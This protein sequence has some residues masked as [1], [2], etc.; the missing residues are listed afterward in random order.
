MSEGSH[1]P[2]AKPDYD[3]V[4]KEVVQYLFRD[5]LALLFPEVEQVIDWNHDPE[6]VNVELPKLLPH[7]LRKLRRPDLVA[8]VQLADGTA[9]LIVVHVEIQ[10][11]PD[12][13]FAERMFVYFYHLRERHQ[14][15]VVSLA[16]L[17]DNQPSWNPTEYRYERLGTRV[18]F[19]YHAK[20][21]IQM[22]ET[23]LQSTENPFALFVRAHIA[24]L[25]H[26]G[27]YALLAEEKKRLFRQMLE[28]GYNARQVRYLFQVVDYLMSLPIDIE[29]EVEA[30]VE[31]VRR[32]RRRKWVAP[33]ERLI[34]ERG[35]LQGMEQ[36]VREGTARTIETLLKARFG[37]LPQEVHARLQ[38]IQSPDVLLELSV[39]AMQAPNLQAFMEDLRRATPEINPSSSEKSP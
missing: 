28:G 17:A 38:A 13:Q 14:M 36:G 30:L 23:F 7:N 33:R 9:T 12:P 32:R 37:D 6:F 5:F 21:L 26:R 31:E 24:S 39:G 29:R 20:K 18:H 16:V 11:S 8:K 27:N 4:W 10:V 15:D 2:P 1:S 25:R 22:D 3:A 19:E 35:L 34:L